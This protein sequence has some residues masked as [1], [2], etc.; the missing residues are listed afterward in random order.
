[1]IGWI[2]LLSLTLPVE[3]LVPARTQDQVHRK[4]VVVTHDARLYESPSGDK[5]KKSNFM[6]IYF[7][8]EGEQNNRLPVTLEP[9]AEQPDGWVAKTDVV[10]WNT[11]QMINFEPQSGR[12]LVRIYDSAACAQE[13]A[14]TGEPGACKELGSEPQ[15]VGKAR[16]DY[17]LLIPVFQSQDEIYQGGFVRVTA[18]GPVV[19]PQTDGELSGQSQQGPVNLGYDLVLV[20]DATASMQKWFR[21]TTEALDSFVRSVSDQIGSGEMRRPFRVGLLFYRDRKILQDCDIGFLT[22]WQAELTNDI[23]EVTQ[24]LAQA[25]E[26]TCGSDEAAEA[27]L[28]G[29]SRAVQDPKWNDGHFKVVLLIGD[30]PPHSPAARDKNPLGLS[31]DHIVNLS[32][33]RNIRFLTLKIGIADTA[34]FEQLA[35]RGPDAVQ[36]RFRA[37]EPDPSAFQQQ[38]LAA[39]KDEWAL[40]TK[41]EKLVDAGITPQA[42]RA[43]PSLAEPFDVDQ[44]D[45]PIIIANL[46]PSSSGEAPPEFVEG[47]VPKRIKKQLAMG[48]YVFMSKNQTLRLANVIQNIALAAESGLTEGPDAFIQNLRS[49]LA[50][51]LNVPPEDLFRAGESLDGMMRKAQVLPFKTTV[52]RFSAEEINTWKPADFERLNTILTEKTELLR[53]FAQRP[54]NFRLFGR[55]PYLYIPRDIFP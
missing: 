52:L 40:L 18:E 5:G 36:G 38:L 11:L 25:Q 41:A 45:L 10:E 48:E 20:V 49:S 21:P 13:L 9:N 30:S 28:D 7:L 32:S 26:A 34:E 42:L 2:F 35:F 44:Y 39:L 14:L 33:E 1:M 6:Q 12:E 23:Q 50:A 16:S 17:A 15:R 22:K 3:A 8:L 27:V 4:A 43:D 37:I 29:V 31:V 24:A 51:M 19:R 47:W 46:P 53:E 54:S 55:T